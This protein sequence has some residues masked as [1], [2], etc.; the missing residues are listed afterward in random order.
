M[1][2]LASEGIYAGGLGE[3]AATKYKLKRYLEEGF[4]ITIGRHT[5]GGP[6]V[7][8]R[9]GDFSHKLD[10][11]SFCSIADDVSIF[12]GN[13]GRHDADRLS[14][15]PMTSIF[16][17]AGKSL[18]DTT[19]NLSVFIGSD[20]WIGRGALIM[21]GITIGDGA[22]IAARAVVTKDVEPYTIVGGVPA[23]VLRNR[24]PPD[25]VENLKKLKWWLWD[26]ETISKNIDL[27]VDHNFSDKIAGHLQQAE[28]GSK[29]PV[30]LREFAL[31]FLSEVGRN[32]VRWP[33]ETTQRAYT[34]AA[35]ENLLNRTIDFAEKV[36]T[37]FPRLE[38]RD[39][40]GLDYGVGWGRMASVM[41]AFASPDCLDCCDPW[42]K[43]LSLAKSCGLSNR[44]ILTPPVLSGDEFSRK[45]DLIYAYSIFT[46]LPEPDFVQNVRVL[47]N[48]LSPGGM[49]IFTVREPHFLQYL[50][51]NGKAKNAALD[52]NGFWFGNAQNANYGDAV[53]SDDWIKSNLSSLGEVTSVA[54]LP[55]EPY[56]RILTI[57]QR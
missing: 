46:H 8:W 14:T 2:F 29:E 23:R 1:N 26:D 44:M 45:Y 31:P 27:F 13:H 33:A 51:K 34:G 11:G 12:V 54:A 18:V 37:L 40:T 57:T 55:S 4:P 10:I 49:M 30:N 50:M 28:R 42:E 48:S 22:V 24:F 9:R 19:T 53:V 7:H 52:E 56:Q 17:Y 16:K 3:E 47:V 15:F 32:G 25:T 35:G 38:K 36:R 43:S 21:A 6:K 20:V 39:W 5:Y 41:S